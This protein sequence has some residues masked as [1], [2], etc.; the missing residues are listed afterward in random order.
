MGGVEGPLPSLYG[1]RVEVVPQATILLGVH[2]LQRELI[3]REDAARRPAPAKKVALI[4]EDAGLLKN[5]GTR[6]GRRSSEN[7]PSGHDRISPGAHG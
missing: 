6:F 5:T 2:D 1:E 3:V 7:A 4:F